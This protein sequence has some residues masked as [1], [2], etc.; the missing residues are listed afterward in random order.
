MIQISVSFLLTLL[1]APLSLDDVPSRAQFLCHFAQFCFSVNAIVP[2]ILNN[3]DLLFFFGQCNPF[4]YKFFD[5]ICQ[6]Y[7]TANFQIKQFDGSNKFL[8]T[9]TTSILIH[10]NKI[11]CF[12]AS[13]TFSF[14]IFNICYNSNFTKQGQLPF[15]FAENELKIFCYLH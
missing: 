9:K 8:L 15:T 4:I 3:S 13:E 14:Y 12:Q 10:S 6:Q 7:I 1:K 11:N 2:I 5:V